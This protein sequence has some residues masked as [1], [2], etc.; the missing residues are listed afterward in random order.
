MQKNTIIIAIAIVISILIG[1]GIGVFIPKLK[2]ATLPE[3]K[4]KYPYIEE[5]DYEINIEG[6]KQILEELAQ[7]DDK[8]SITREVYHYIYYDDE[9]AQEQFLQD[10]KQYPYNTN[11]DT[12]TKCVVVIVNSTTE[13]KVIEEQMLNILN[14]SKKYNIEYDG[15][16]TIICNG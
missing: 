1:I 3:W 9:K 7:N 16:E 13:E 10:L 12:E 6:D 8:S 4:K 2:Q 15:W 14:L 5:S 11:V